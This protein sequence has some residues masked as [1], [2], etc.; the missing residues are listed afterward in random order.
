MSLMAMFL[1]GERKTPDDREKTSYCQEGKPAGGKV[2]CENTGRRSNTASALEAS[3]VR[4]NLIRDSAGRV[5]WE[6]GCPERCP[7]K[8]KPNLSIRKRGGEEKTC[9]E[10]RRGLA[11]AL[12]LEQA[13]RIRIGGKFFSKKSW[14]SATKLYWQGEGK[15]DIEGGP[16]VSKMGEGSF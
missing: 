4:K 8:E 10:G 7:R 16:G 12:L 9:V 2:P 3:K 1:K 13:E 15:S 11:G 14:V 6:W 5:G